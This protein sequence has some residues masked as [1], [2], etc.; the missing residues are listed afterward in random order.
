[1]FFCF[2]QSFVIL[3]D[4]PK[5]GAYQLFDQMSRRCSSA[6]LSAAFI[7]RYSSNPLPLDSPPLPHLLIFLLYSAFSLP[8]SSVAPMM[9]WTD[10]HYR[11]LARIITKHAWLYTEMIAAQT[12]VH[13]Q[14]NLDR[15]LAFPPQQHPIVLQ[16]GGS[17]VESLAKAAKLSHAYGYD[18]INLNCGC[19]SPKV[20][21]HGCFG[22]SLMLNP[23]VFYS[24]S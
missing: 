15:F 8:P 11:T 22:V 23:K 12:L 19:P 10:N 6:L 24:Y 5:C 9:E 16:L 1:H 21:G 13:Q 4:E 7:L 3:S 14:T 20:A 2:Q 18:E 17:N